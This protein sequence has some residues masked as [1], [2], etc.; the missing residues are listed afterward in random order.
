[1]RDL[2]E[3]YRTVSA[4]DVIL[5]LEGNDICNVPL[6]TVNAFLSLLPSFSCF[7]ENASKRN[8]A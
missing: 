7:D 5:I 4:V 6:A 8:F 2:E 3:I 1:M